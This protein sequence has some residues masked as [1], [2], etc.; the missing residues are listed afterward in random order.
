ME[1]EFINGPDAIE[2]EP[3]LFAVSAL[4]SPSTGIVDAAG[5]A[6]SF[7][8][9]TELNGASVALETKI[10]KITQNSKILISGT[11]GGEEFEAEF[12]ILINACGHGAHKLT[13]SYLSLIHI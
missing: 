5:L 2:K 12:D 7:Q 4:V 10:T 8:H 11:S 6:A 3:N 1:L 9:Q 13:Q